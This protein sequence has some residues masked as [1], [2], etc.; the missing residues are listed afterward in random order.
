MNVDWGGLR[1]MEPV[2]RQFGYDRGTPVDRYYIER[3]LSRNSSAVFGRVLEIGDDSYTRR[4]GGNRVTRRDVLHVHAGNPN[5]TIIGDLATATT[6]PPDSFDCAIVTQTLQFTV[7]PEAALRNLHRILR[8]GGVL[9]GTVPALTVVSSEAD[10]WNSTWYW[11]FTPA[12]ISKMVHQVF[13]PDRCTFEVHGNVLAS[14]CT[15]Q[16]VA[17]EDVSIAEL[18]ADDPEFPVLLTFRCMKAAR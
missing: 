10:E 6:I 5:A 1:Q 7:N 18:E 14:V 2:S 15:L 16:G 13:S 12:L 4:F 11:S 8:P 17:V 3:F 9:L